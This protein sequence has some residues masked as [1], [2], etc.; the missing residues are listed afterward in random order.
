M[1]AIG[2]T[3]TQDL[4]KLCNQAWLNSSTK[5]ITTWSNSISLNCSYMK[6]KKPVIFQFEIEIM[7][8]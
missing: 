3:T 8:F 5:N 7:S 4:R 6:E 2:F 1:F